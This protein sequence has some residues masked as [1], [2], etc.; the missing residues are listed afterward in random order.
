M[1]KVPKVQSD[2]RTGPKRQHFLALVLLVFIVKVKEFAKVFRGAGTWFVE[3]LHKMSKLGRGGGAIKGEHEQTRCLHIP[4]LVR[5][6]NT[7]LCPPPLS[8]NIVKRWQPLPL[9]S[10]HTETNS[11]RL[12][13]ERKEESSVK[14]FLDLNSSVSSSRLLKIG[15]GFQKHPDT[16]AR[17]CLCEELSERQFD[18]N[19]FCGN[20]SANE[21]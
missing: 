6:S 12:A 2:S 17:K 21:H 3:K 4:A 5:A 8:Y 18:R 20:L 15:Y 13:G 19:L 7:V 10:C 1:L 11:Y 9:R 16:F 14:L